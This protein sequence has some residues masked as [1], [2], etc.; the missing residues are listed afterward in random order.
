MSISGLIVIATGKVYRDYTKDML[1]SAYEYFHE[2][3]DPLIFTDE[4]EDFLTFSYY[5]GGSV[6][7][8][9]AKDYPNETLYR[10]HTMLE[11]EA[12]LS[13]YDYLFY[14]DADMLFVAPTT[15][16]ILH[17]GLVATLHPGFYGKKGECETRQASTAYCV[18]NMAYYAGGFQGGSSFWYLDAARVLRGRIQE[19]RNNNIVAKWHD[20]SHWNCY[21]SDVQHAEHVSKDLVKVLS[22]NYCYPEDYDN[23]SGWTKEQYPAILVA[24]EKR[25]RG[26]HPRFPGVKRK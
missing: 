18:D 19:D 15:D 5:G 26:N 11:Q 3:F 17:D 16:E 1:E 10:Y 22:P 24:L 6:F 9:K 7:Y 23:S 21:I 8:T 12:E 25:K 4:P 20:E 14:A 13:K 2:D